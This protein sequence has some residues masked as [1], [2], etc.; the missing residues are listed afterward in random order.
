LFPPGRQQAHLKVNI[1][2]A[3]YLLKR[4]IT[5]RIEER[6]R[7]KE[8]SKEEVQAII[9]D[10]ISE[11]YKELQSAAR[12]PTFQDTFG[13]DLSTKYHDVI[14][15]VIVQ[16]FEK[17]DIP[18]EARE[19]L[20]QIAVNIFYKD[21]FIYGYSGVVI[22]GFGDKE[23]FPVTRSYVFEGVVEN[24]L[25]FKLTKHREI[26]FDVTAYI[27][28]FAQTDMVYTFVQGIDPAYENFTRNAVRFLMQEFSETIVNKLDMLDAEQKQKLRDEA[29]QLS[30]S[31]RQTFDESLKRYQQRSCTDGIVNAVGILPKDELAAMAES[32]VNL[33]V[34]KR[35]VS[36]SAETVGGPVDVAVITKG[37][38]F[39]WIK[40]KHY[41]QQEM[42]AQF[43]ANYY[44][45][46]RME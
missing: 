42:N 36:M 4:R 45:K 34:F 3:F 30:E 35:K 46:D 1:G 13:S 41:F 43:L 20:R 17:L 33:T 19:Q 32:L 21:E 27:I 44:I 8:I 14:D 40:R 39:I 29:K 23:I 38:G 6:V 16:V 11:R 26:N 22:A 31:H 7:Q 25:K 37:D 2:I 5:E 10:I 9:L 28:P 12:L 18:P 24:K 15:Q